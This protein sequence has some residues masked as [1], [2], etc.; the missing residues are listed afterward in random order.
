MKK[1]ELFEVVTSGLQEIETTRSW[2]KGVGRKTASKSTSLTLQRDLTIS[3]LK[4]V[5]EWLEG[6]Q[7]PHAELLRLKSYHPEHAW[8][9][10]F[11]VATE[12]REVIAMKKLIKAFMTM[13]RNR[14]SEVKIKRVKEAE[15]GGS[16]D[17]A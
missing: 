4:V 16:D 15:E 3:G 5:H 8:H 14:P 11:A 12:L 10:L 2:A 1:A 17:Q 9:L 7:N 6:I 13:I